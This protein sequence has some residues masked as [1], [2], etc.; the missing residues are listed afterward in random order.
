MK[1]TLT[2]IILTLSISGLLAWNNAPAQTQSSSANENTSIN[3]I[4]IQQLSDMVQ[5]RSWK[6]KK[7]KVL[8][9]LYTNWCGWCKRMDASTYKDPEIINY[10]NEHYYAVRFDAEMRD[11]INFGGK[12][13]HYVKPPGARR[14][15]NELAIALGNVNGRMGYP[16]TVFMDEDMQLLQALPGFKDSKSMLP[17]LVY[18][19]EDYAKTTPWDDFLKAYPNNE[20]S[21]KE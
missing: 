10:I 19:G 21:D 2:A 11:S 7:K 14:G 8:V 9:D 16:T 3:W 5:R 12:M 6:K 13:Y 15:T 20:H 4:S 1:Q 18:F 17:I